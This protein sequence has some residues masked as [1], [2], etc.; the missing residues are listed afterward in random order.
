MPFAP[1]TL[2]EY[3][4]DCYRDLDGIRNTAR[5]MTVTVECTSAM[6]AESPGAIHVDGTARPQI[7]DRETAPDFHAILT[8]YHARTGVPS[9]VNTSF[10]MHEE[11]IVCTPDDA[12]RAFQAGSLDWLALGSYMIEGTGRGR[13]DRSR[14]LASRSGDEG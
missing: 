4:D 1:A 14:A 11:P 5:F 10:N 3:A 6:R 8:E 9:V 2:A 7:V 13:Q 12:I